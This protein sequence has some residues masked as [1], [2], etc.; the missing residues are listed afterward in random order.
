MNIKFPKEEV[1]FINDIEKMYNVNNYSGIVKQY[2]KIIDNI[3]IIL[4]IKKD[5]IDIIVEALF[6][7]RQFDTIITFVES[8]RDKGFE[9]FLWYFYAFASIIGN[10]DI[11]LAKTIIKKSKLLNDPDIQFYYSEDGANYVN[12]LGM[13]DA[14]LDTQAPC[15]IMINF[16]NDL[17]FESLQKTLNANYVVMRTFDLINI[18]Y[19]DGANQELIELFINTLQII[20]EIDS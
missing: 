7:C 4:N 11:Y 16:I 17:I 12:I 3:E 14:I 18:L 5:I 6:Y 8:L 13:N 20:F 2:N 19:E 1:Q 9:E 10:D 15:L